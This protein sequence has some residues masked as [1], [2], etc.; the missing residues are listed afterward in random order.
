MAHR[1][2][3]RAQADLDDIWFY[4]A[5]ESGSIE[6][7]NRLIDTITNRFLLL[8]GFLYIGRS[9]DEDLGPGC[10]SLTVGEHIIVYC[11]ENGDVLILRVVH[12]RRDLDAL[13]GHS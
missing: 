6:I 11:V 5:K 7:A 10:R 8:A 12:G 3:P 13:F 2:S 4:A 1:V 9:R